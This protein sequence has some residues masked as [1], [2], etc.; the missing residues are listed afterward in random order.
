M[1]KNIF[2]VGNGN[3]FH[4][5]EFSLCCFASFTINLK[6]M[7]ARR[8]TKQAILYN[9]MAIFCDHENK[10]TGNDVDYLTTL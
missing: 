8:Q 2:I 7:G 5:A 6:F 3:S 9:F 1:F 10:T 4:C